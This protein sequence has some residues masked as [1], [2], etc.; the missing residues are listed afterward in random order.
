MFRL[1]GQVAIIVLLLPVFFLSVCHSEDSDSVEIV[2]DDEIQEFPIGTGME[3]GKVYVGEP[4][5]LDLQDADIHNV[6]RLLAEV[7]NINIVVSD[8]VKGKV[9]M[10]LRNVPWDQALDTIVSTYNLG[11]I[12]HGSGPNDPPEKQEVEIFSLEN[13]PTTIEVVKVECADA[14]QFANALSSLLSDGGTIVPYRPTNSLIIKDRASVVAKI[15]GII[16][17]RPCP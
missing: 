3:P 9:T 4:V 6:L 11:I 5:N 7:G 2:I 14:A 12:W 8:K 16:E 13:D 15:I 10:R 17:R 1:S